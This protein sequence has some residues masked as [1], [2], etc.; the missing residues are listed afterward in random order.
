MQ[1]GAKDI[2]IK[3][4]E[5]NTTAANDVKIDGAWPRRGHSPLNGL[6][7]TVSVETGKLLDA[8]EM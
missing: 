8:N 3:N 1:N 6:V 4:G 2:R 7:A 5:E